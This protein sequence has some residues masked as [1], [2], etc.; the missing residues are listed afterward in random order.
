MVLALLSVCLVDGCEFVTEPL[1][2]EMLA[3]SID[4]ICCVA[5]LYPLPRLCF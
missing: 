4:L 1:L 3:N 5:D 2:L